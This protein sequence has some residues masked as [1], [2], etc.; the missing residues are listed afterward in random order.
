MTVW[1]LQTRYKT[2]GAGER[3][4]TRYVVRWKVEGG[5]FDETFKLYAQAD[6]FRSDLKS[7]AKRGEAFDIETGL[8]ESKMP[9]PEKPADVPWVQ[10]ACKY[11]DMKWDD[12]SPKHRASIADSLVA[13]TLQ[14]APDTAG[15]PEI[16]EASRALRWAFNKSHRELRPPERFADALLWF[17]KN[18]WTVAEFSAPE[19]FRIVYSA[20]ARKRDGK[21]AARSTLKLRRAA[22][23]EALDYAIEC[24]L[25]DANPYS[26]LAVKKVKTVVRQVDKRSVVNPIQFRTIL[27]EVRRIAPRLVLFYALLFFAGLRPE[28]AKAVRKDDFV[29]PPPVFNEATGEWEY[30]DGEI[31][32]CDARP[33]IAGEW[34]DSGERSEARGQLKH[35]EEDEGR[36]V[37]CPAELTKLVHEHIDAYGVAPDGRLV[38]GQRDDRPLSS[39]VYL[40]VWGKARE[41]AFVPEV[42]ASPLGK[43]PY[44]LRHAAVSVWL[45]V[46]G[47]PVRVAAW[48]GHTV[49][50]LLRVYAKVI[51]GGEQQARARL[52]AWLKGA[53]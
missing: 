11:A 1:S 9:P 26:E 23:R 31:H 19:R 27:N 43:R 47:D 20:L 37:P 52:A 21:R 41:V 5:R 25:L 14:S 40:R 8:P 35:R 13:I 48:A 46:T 39:S 22:H 33:D 18:C 4:P 42:V 6:S 53:A 17:E 29:L 16:G 50:V 32:L 10:F 28:E 12:I 3:V 24:K 2:D 34:T 7:A 49:A 38:R 30:E 15:R 45:S 36:I 51:D 44:D